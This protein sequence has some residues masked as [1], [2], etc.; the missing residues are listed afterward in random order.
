MN[1]FNILVLDGGGVRGLFTA[2]VLSRLHAEF[3]ELVNQIDLVCGVS[4][5]SI[6]A[7]AIASGITPE[8][9]ASFYKKS[10]PKVFK[11]SYWD[12]VVDLGNL[13]GADYDY[14]NLK[15]A[16]KENLGT[17]TLG[18][19]IKKVVIPTFD[20]DN[21][22]SGELRTWKPKFYNS[23]QDSDLGELVVDIAVRSAAA[24]SYFPVYQGFIDGGLVTNTPCM[25]AIAQALDV[26]TANQKLENIRLLSLGTGYC[27]TFISGKKLDWGVSQWAKFLVPIFTDAMMFSTNYQCEKLLGSNYHRL[28]AILSKKVNLDDFTKLDYLVDE[29]NS[30][31]LVPTKEWL[32]NNWKNS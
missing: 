3:P 24:P 4:T 17:K 18:E 15:K 31:D 25:P 23:Y 6:I 8:D 22:A 26:N 20:L 19:L 12:D 7:L 1:T 9:I 29:A 10:L 27:P 11:D 14:N 16:L 30:L 21:E 5:G 28:D 2:Q 32:V 13:I